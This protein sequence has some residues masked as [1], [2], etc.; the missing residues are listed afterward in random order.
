MST[1]EAERPDEPGWARRARLAAGA[2]PGAR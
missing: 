2:A 1:A